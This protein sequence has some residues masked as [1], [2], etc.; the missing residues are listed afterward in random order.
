MRL[1]QFFAV[2]TILWVAL[3]LAACQ[4]LP[5]VVTP[6]PVPM[7][8]QNEAVARRFYEAINQG[9]LDA[10]DEFVAADL[11][12]HNLVP[13]QAPGLEGLKQAIAGIRAGFPDFQVTNEEIIAQGDRV[14][15]R[16]TVRG[17]HQGEFEG[18]PPTGKPVEIGAIDIWRVVDGKLVEV[19]HVEELLSLMGQ[20]GAIPTGEAAPPAAE[21]IA[22][23]LNG[24]MGVLVDPAGPVWVIDS[25]IG[26]DTELS[27]INPF[28]GQEAPASFGQ[29]ARV[30]QIAPDST[31]TEAASLPSVVIN[32]PEAAGGARLA[33]LE[34]TL[35]ATTGFWI[36][37][38]KAER[39]ALMPSVV[40]IEAG[41][42]TQVADTWQ[43]EN[44]QNPDGF[45]RESHPYGLAAGPDGKL[46]VAEAGAN[47]LLKI[48]PTTGQVELV[49][50]FEGVPSPL[51][52]SN[53]GNAM[54]SDPVPT[55]VAFDR[56][57]TLYVSLLPGFPFLPGSAKV[58]T[59]DP[60]TGA[61]SDYATGLTMLT[62][63]RLGPDGN[64]YAISFGQFIE[65]GPVPNQGAIIRV[66]KGDASEVLV[67]GLPF[68]TSIDFNAAGDAYVTI[69]GLGAP[70]SGEVVLYKGLTGL[71]GQPVSEIMEEPAP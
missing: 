59:V 8:E 50:V 4:P 55:G 24:P 16:S 21:T 58:V 26:G 49:V 34:G 52:N 38:P 14:V 43:L 22:T 39:P 9:N 25:G 48:D 66:R 28:S 42:V 2:I 53:R 63:L 67:E 18:I 11:V 13:G 60:E 41:E 33:V 54:E 40:K 62:D 1:Y 10:F 6:T 29:S 47:D 44:S 61:V 12:D 32:P 3:F 17:T 15:V 46:W 37:G 70:G 56:E 69:N 51:P 35:Y 57:G 36:E 71:A 23:G 31:P 19:W 20:I 65:E 27:F 68:P 64:L 7:A 5:I 30:L 45:V